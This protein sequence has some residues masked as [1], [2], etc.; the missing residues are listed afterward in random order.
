MTEFLSAAHTVLRSCHV[1]LGFLGLVVFWLIAALPKGTR[2]HVRLGRLFAW[3]AYI[4]GGT[5]LVSSIWAIVHIDS[6]APWIAYKPAELQDGMRQSLVFFFALLLYLALATITGAVF[7]VQVMRLKSRHEGLR[8]T[9][10]PMWELLTAA[11]AGGLVVFGVAKLVTSGEATGSVPRAAASI[12][13]ILGLLGLLGAVTELRYIFGPRPPRREWLYK[14]VE[15][16]FGTGIAFHTAFAVFG[17]NRLLGF[18]LS[19]AWALAPWI[20]PPIVGISL[21][22]V[23]VARLRQRHNSRS[24]RVTLASRRSESAAA[25]PGPS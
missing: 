9:S 16:M 20:V 12:P 21:T 4:V 6:F 17:S 1:G 23:Y 11:T 8:R 25:S 18:N 13:I 2:L 14:H 5:A 3:I 22:A 19:G 10:V 24:L 7:G 15:Q